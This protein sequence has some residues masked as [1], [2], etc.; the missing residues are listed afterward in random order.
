MQNISE[1]DEL[2]KLISKLPGLGPKSAK[3]I[4]LKLINNRD[5]L[6]KPMANSLAKVFKNIIRCKSCGSLKS[7]SKGCANCEN[8]NEKFNKICVVEDIADQWSIENSNIYKG[9]FHILGGTISSVG[10]RKEDLLINS[11]VDRV[12]NEKIEEVILATSATV[13]GQTTA[14]YIQDSLKHLK[15]KITKLAQGLPVG[16]EIDSLD[17]G[18]LFSA[19]KNRSN[20]KSNS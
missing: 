1:I 11:L 16:G 7:N 19:F 14:Y 9:Y 3:R 8:I 10:Q 18:T 17:D 5:E 4:V 2:I 13:E 6:I 12:T 15:V 20:L